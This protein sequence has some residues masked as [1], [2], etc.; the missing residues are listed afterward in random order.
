MR[1]RRHKTLTPV[2]EAGLPTADL[3]TL[4]AFLMTGRAL[5]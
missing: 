4:G 3:T 2:D 1:N 5:P